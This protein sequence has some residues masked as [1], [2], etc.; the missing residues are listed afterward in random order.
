MARTG[1]GQDYGVVGEFYNRRL[2]VKLSYFENSEEYVRTASPLT[3]P[4][5]Q[6]LGRNA[7]FD[8][9]GDG[10]N[11]RSISD[12]IGSDYLSQKTTGYEFEMVGY[13]F[14]R[15]VRVLANVD[16]NK[17]SQ[18]DRYPLSLG[19]L[20]ANSSSFTD[21]LRDAGG[22]LDTTRSVNGSPSVAVVNPAV[23]AAIASEHTNAV[24][25]YNNIWTQAGTVVNDRALV[26]EKKMVVNFAISYE[27]QE[28]FARGLRLGLNGQ[29]K[30]NNHVGYRTADTLLDSSGNP[31]L[32][33]PSSAFNGN[34][35]YVDLPLEISGNAAYRWR[36]KGGRQVDVN[37]RI[38]N[39]LSRQA[40]FYAG[41]NN[42]A[43]PPNGDFSKV[44]R[45][46]VP[47]RLGGF[48]VPISFQLT[49]AISF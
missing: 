38:R 34:A 8:A 7:A 23:T 24:I 13:L 48:Q 42:I 30:G 39:L 43:R 14:S 20:A 12:V 46:G 37:L 33:Y 31:A 15:S 21:V 35:V 18:F 1:V 11:R 49:T 27:F 47:S 10:R 4:I 2:T 3:S 9:A 44:N 32:V 45:V 25:D 29:W 22:T 17:V 6:L 41:G 19:F 28:S 36:L 40:V 16:T 5:N 26:S